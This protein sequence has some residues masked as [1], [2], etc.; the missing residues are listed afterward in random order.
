MFNSKLKE[1][2]IT[3]KKENK[4]L[5]HLIEEVYRMMDFTFSKL[6]KR[7][8]GNT[9]SLKYLKDLKNNLGIAIKTLDIEEN[10]L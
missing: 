5:S 8:I 2:I 6:E 7:R 1:E 10:S 9:R 3:L 4:N